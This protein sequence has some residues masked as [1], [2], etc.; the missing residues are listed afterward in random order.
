VSRLDDDAVVLDTRPYRDRHQIVVFLTR[1]HGTV[2]AVLRGARAG[3]APPAA[4]TQILSVV[5][6]IAY[7]A[8][9]AELATC[10]RVDLVRSSYPLAADLSRSSAAAVI[11]ELLATFTAPGDDDPR[12]FRLGAALLEA[13]LGGVDADAAVG[14]AQVWCLLF[15]GLLAAAGDDA[16]GAASRPDGTGLFIAAC[17]RLRPSELPAPAPEDVTEWLDGRVRAEAD[18]RLPALDFYRT[19]GRREA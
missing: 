8:P 16:S 11:A 9:S 7:Q 15:A 1:R 2:R 3:K 19:I 17:R 6:V 12:P 5:R 4:A 14:Y 18:R 13:L 10:Q